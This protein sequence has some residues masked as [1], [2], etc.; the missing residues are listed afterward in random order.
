MAEALLKKNYTLVS[1]GTD[2][3]LVLLGKINFFFL[4]K[5]NIFSNV[6][7]HFMLFRLT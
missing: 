4:I 7:F 2:N 3:H 1:G 5:S 6:D